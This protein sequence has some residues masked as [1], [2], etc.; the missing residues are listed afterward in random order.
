MRRLGSLKGSVPLGRGGT[1]GRG[2][3][4]GSRVGGRRGLLGGRLERDDL[5]PEMG[6]LL[7]QG[8]LKRN[9]MCM[10]GMDCL[11]KESRIQSHLTFEQ[12]IR[13]NSL[14]QAGTRLTAS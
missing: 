11:K 12:A 14:F 3:G 1:Q 13:R 6:H 10:I 2:G 5:G 9:S 7:F 8:G 4:V